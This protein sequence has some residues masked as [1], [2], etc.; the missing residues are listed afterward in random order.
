MK[1]SG[2]KAVMKA[3]HQELKRKRS[4]TV[5]YLVLR[6]MVIL[7]MVAQFFN[8]NFE[9]VFLCLLTLVL[10]LLPTIFERRLKIDLPD[11]LEIVIML[12]IFAAEILGEI[13]AFYTTFQGWD[14]M[15]HTI[16]GFLCAAIGFCLVDMFDRNERFSLTLSPVFM[17]IVAFC[18]SMTIGVLWEFFEC[19]MDQLF[20]LDMQKDTVLSSISSVMLDPTGGNTP[21][22]IKGI[23]DVIV[24]ANGEQIPLGVGGYLDVGI[25]DTMKDLVVNFV[26]AVVFSFI[27]YFYVK[28]RGKGRF[29][30][31]FIPRVLSGAEEEKQ[32]SEQT[33]E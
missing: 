23:T 25:L 16:N 24:V 5:V 27:G 7:I 4:V 20:L 30:R 11:T 13:R 3:A 6:L 15:L 17:A 22:A 14:T 28:G 12:F 9:N 29:A 31:R 21:V 18:F 32:E 8:R 33:G 2:V 26:G 10:F 19:A 1:K